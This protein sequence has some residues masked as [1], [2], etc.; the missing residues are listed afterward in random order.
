[1]PPIT[2]RKMHNPPRSAT[3]TLIFDGDDTL[4]Q[5]MPLY[6]RSKRRFFAFMENLGFEREEVEAIFER[7]DAKNVDHWGFTVERFRQSMVQVLQ[8]FLL[9]RGEIPRPQQ[10]EQVSHIATSVSRNQTRPVAGA[11]AT[12]RVLN[13][14]YRMILLTKG[15]YALQER[16]VSESGFADLFKTVFIVERKDRSS[17]ERIC[18]DLALDVKSTWSIGDSLR[19]DIKPALAAGLG[20]FW[21]P[22]KTWSYENDVEEHHRRLM[23]LK[24]ISE[25]PRV[26][27]KVEERQ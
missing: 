17:F 16:R 18:E 26:L 5:T 10:I 21:I 1:M 25:L 19:S 22:Q 6:T 11:H 20:G 7:Q 12:L 14:K 2:I 27:R 23:R 13:T 3:I 15:E 8:E 9:V 4:W 24:T